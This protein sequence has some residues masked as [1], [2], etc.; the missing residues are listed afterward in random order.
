LLVDHGHDG[1]GVGFE[2]AEDEGIRV[3]C[4]DASRHGGGGEVGKVRRDQSGCTTR[5]GGGEDVPIV[6]VRK[7]E[8]GDETFVAADHSV[9]HCDGH[10]PAGAANSVF[11]QVGSI[12]NEVV[13]ALIEDPFGPAGLVEAGD[14][15]ADQE[16][17]QPSRVQD[18]RVEHRNKRRHRQ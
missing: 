3:H 17:P 13:E 12:V 6:A 14:R 10:Q 16:I 9:W 7:L 1:L 11:G 5:D 18:V 8:P 4:S 15:K 2:Q